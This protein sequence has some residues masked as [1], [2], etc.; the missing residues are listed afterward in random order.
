MGT[1]DIKKILA[2]AQKLYNEG[3]WRDSNSLIDLNESSLATDEEIA[4]ACRLRGWNWYYIG[5]KG[6]DD[7]QTS[8]GRSKREFGQ[9]FHR[10]SDAKKKLSI[11][12]GLPLSLWVLE[13]RE[14]AWKVSDQAIEEF[15]DEPSV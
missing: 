10:T 8:L 14:E 5:I 11:L 2:E 9:A 13:A 3:K 12:N 15:P 1:V 6:L 7:K 4:E